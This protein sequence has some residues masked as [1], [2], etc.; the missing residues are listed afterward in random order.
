M[1]PF[2]KQEDQNK[3]ISNQVKSNNQTGV[4]L[5]PSEV[6]ELLTEL[7]KSKYKIMSDGTRQIDHDR[8]ALIKSI[9]DRASKDFGPEWDKT[10]SK[11][12][13]GIEIID[14][15][16]SIV[17]INVNLT[18]IELHTQIDYIRNLGKHPEGREFLKKFIKDYKDFFGFDMSENIRAILQ[19]NDKDMAVEQNQK[20]LE[21]AQKQLNMAIQT[22]KD[23]KN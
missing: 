18:E 4:S 1:W 11:Y 8:I 3:I 20:A 23:L 5:N 9:A 19:L 14:K 6:A 17:N 13:K 12:A 21:E 22:V 2:R 15:Y 16:E 7:H 10:Y